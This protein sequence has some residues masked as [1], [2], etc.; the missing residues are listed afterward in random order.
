MQKDRTF[1]FHATRMISSVWSSDNTSSRRLSYII[2]HGRRTSEGIG[3]A[4]RYR[5]HATGEPSA[6]VHGSW[7]LRG[8]GK[9][10]CGFTFTLSDRSLWL[11][12]RRL[13]PVSPA[14]SALPRERYRSLAPLF[15]SRHATNTKAIGGQAAG[16]PEEVESFRCPKIDRPSL[17]APRD[18]RR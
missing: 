3:N 9:L 1:N 12:A 7:M 13:P 15:H 14:R 4:I 11:I 10:L 18:G 6:P 17:P 5:R 2:E 8:R 16:L